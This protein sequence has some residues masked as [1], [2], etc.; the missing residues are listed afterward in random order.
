MSKAMYDDLQQAYEH[1]RETPSA[2]IRKEHVRTQAQPFIRGARVLD[3]AC[4]S[5]G[6]TYDLLA[7]GA[8]SVVGVDVSPVM[9]EAAKEK[10]AKLAAQSRNGLKEKIANSLTFVVGDARDGQMYEGGPFDVVFAAWLLNYAPTRADMQAMFATIAAN[11]RPDGHMFA[12]IPPASDDPRATIE[13]HNA[14]RPPRQR[15]SGFFAANIRDV[16]DGIVVDYVGYTPAG[17]DVKI[18]TYHLTRATHEETARAAGLLGELRWI[19]QRVPD[20]YLD[21]TVDLGVPRKE[22]ET[23]DVEPDHSLLV[24]R[25]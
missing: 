11:L 7:W 5:G 19:R 3:L 8:A 6:F 10:G 13:A 15:K 21:G 2:V 16:T 20:K 18:M 14:I 1:I 23:Y 12:I 22:L 17:G 24:I 4:G 25:K 9:I